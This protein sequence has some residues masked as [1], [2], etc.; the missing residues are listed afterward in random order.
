MRNLA[1]AGMGGL[2]LFFLAG[3]L[4]VEDEHVTYQDSTGTGTADCAGITQ[5]EENLS[6]IN[7]STCS[8]HSSQAPVLTND[9]ASNRELLI[10]VAAS[11]LT[12][13]YLSTTHSGQAVFTASVDETAFT[14]WVT[15][16][17]DTC[18]TIK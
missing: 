2:F 5:F 16:E 15:T 14:D 17:T 7:V 8:C 12:Y 1:L 6:V 4:V 10:Q 3:C 11:K 18:G 9:A 13:E